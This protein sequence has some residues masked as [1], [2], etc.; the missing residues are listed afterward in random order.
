[1]KL[2]YFV[3]ECLDESDQMFNLRA[4]RKKDLKRTID[5]LDSSCA[6]TF[7]PIKK[8]IVEY[9]SGFDLLEKCFEMY[10]AESQM[11]FVTSFNEALARRPATPHHPDV[12]QSGAWLDCGDANCPD[13]GRPERTNR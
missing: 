3:A 9:S 2:T 6:S 4:L 7:G 13:C 5:T 10:N 8:V 11:I 1:M 12:R